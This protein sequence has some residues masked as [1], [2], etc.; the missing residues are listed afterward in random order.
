MRGAGL[1][2]EWE[3]VVG[4]VRVEVDEAGVDHR[5][6]PHVDDRRRVEP[7]RGRVTIVGDALDDVVVADPHPPRERLGLGCPRHRGDRPRDHQCHGNSLPCSAASLKPPFG[8]GA[9]RLILH[10]M[11]HEFEIGY[12]RGFA[13]LLRTYP[14]PD[15]YPPDD[16]RV[17]WG[18]IFHRGRLDGSARVLVLGQDPAAHETI[19]RR[20]L[21]GEAGQRVQGILAKLGIDR[22]YVM[23]NTFLYS[24]YGQGG[25]ERHK[26]DPGIIDY[27]NKWLDKLAK[28]NELEAIIAL[29]G[30]ADD[31]HTVWRA[32][33]AG[34]A[35]TAAY[36]DI[37]HPTWPM[38]QRTK[39]K[40]QATAEL[41]AN[42]NAGLAPL[43]GVITPDVPTPSF[44]PYG[45][46]F[47]DSDFGPIPERDVPPGLPDWM[48]SVDAWAARR[49]IDE[50]NGPTA[51][52]ADVDEAKRAGIGVKVPRKQRVWHT[53]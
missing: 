41:L 31:A 3:E 18:P 27:R 26:N 2:P 42:W 15:I 1:G 13:S 48:R 40:T 8:D 46:S 17:E 37:T 47:V 4:E 36:A 11:T 43:H 7:G 20:I 38:S 24:V 12:P 16:F 39:T 30:L 14:G 25:G 32:T 22:S 35:C 28:T 10:S 49:P 52:K 5:V 45:T 50:A 21:V 53:T 33:P 34:Q 44:V 6:V 51:T 29:G 19:V 23:V 9:R